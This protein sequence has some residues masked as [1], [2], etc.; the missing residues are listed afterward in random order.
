MGSASFLRRHSRRLLHPQSPPS[1][2]DHPQ[3]V[4]PL[5]HSRGSLFDFFFLLQPCDEPVTSPS[6]FFVLCSLYCS[7]PDPSSF[8]LRLIGSID[9]EL[10]RRAG[11]SR[12]KMITKKLCARSIK[13]EMGAILYRNRSVFPTSSSPFL[14]RREWLQDETKTRWKGGVWVLRKSDMIGRPQDAT[15]QDPGLCHG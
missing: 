1:P 10:V 15:S 13:V 4:V 7:V 2:L 3:A 11:V 8:S 6:L 9:T 5:H 14:R 12:L